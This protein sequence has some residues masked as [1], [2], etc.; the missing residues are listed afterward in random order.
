MNPLFKNIKIIA[1]DV[2]TTLYKNIPELSL[3]FKE[4]CI[5][6][7]AAVRNISYKEAE[8]IFED[9]RLKCGSS[10]MALRT[11]KAGDEKTLLEIQK[12]L[13]KQDY[14]KPD[15]KLLEMF[16]K[17]KKFRH[18]IITNSMKEDDQACLKKLGIAETIFEKIIT[19]EDSGE[20]KPG[21]ASF[22]LLLTTTGLSADQH[23][24]IGD[25]EQVDIVPAKSLG[26]KTILV[27]GKS[28]IADLSLPTVY[29][30]ANVFI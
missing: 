22:Q 21:L 26:M 8:N 1:W 30:V 27:W 16:N 25:R 4:E 12:K 24:Y 15:P 11:L 10:T 14:I 3:K 13:H 29:D 17:L 9:M 23:V 20:P 6:V 2:D 19:V 7:V 5:K 28:D 18:F